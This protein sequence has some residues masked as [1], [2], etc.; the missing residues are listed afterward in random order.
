[1]REAFVTSDDTVSIPVYR[2]NRVAGA[3]VRRSVHLRQG[4]VTER[5][6]GREAVTV[7]AVARAQPGASVCSA[8]RQERAA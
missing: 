4:F 1:M 6:S 7:P 5:G 2:V 8:S 3:L